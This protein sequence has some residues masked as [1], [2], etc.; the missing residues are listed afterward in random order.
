[1]TCQPH[2]PIADWTRN[3]TSH[4]L[5]LKLVGDHP[6][7]SRLIIA[8]CVTKLAFL[9]SAVALSGLWIASILGGDEN[10]SSAPRITEGV[11]LVQ[12]AASSPSALPVCAPP[13]SEQFAYVS[14]IPSL[15]WCTMNG[16]WVRGARLSPR[17]AQS[18]EAQLRKRSKVDFSAKYDDGPSAR[19]LAL[20]ER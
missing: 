19:L 12:L 16:H 20:P 7:V 17:D 13:I 15:W 1:M 2:P 18:A 5:A 14:S 6:S 4:G 11:H 9:G 3:L 8:K 10:S